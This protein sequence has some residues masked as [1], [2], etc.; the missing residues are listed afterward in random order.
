MANF[1][2]PQFIDIEDKIIGPL[3]IRQFIILVCT[4]A[5]IFV[6]NNFFALWLMIILGG[7]IGAIGLAMAFLKING[8]YFSRVVFNA[9]KYFVSP[10]LYVWQRTKKEKSFAVDKVIIA[11]EK[12][13][14]KRL[15]LEELQDFAKKMNNK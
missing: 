2:V 5:V 15:S 10:R 1:Q 7:I 11:P 14:A 8:Q 6:L 13:E 9:F 4:V 12:K 3:A